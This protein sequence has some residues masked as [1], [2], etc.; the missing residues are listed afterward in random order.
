MRMSRAFLS[1]LR[2]APADTE[3][4]SHVLLARSGLLSKLGAGL[5]AYLPA[6]WRTLR[7][8]S[9][10][11]REE[12]DRAGAQE[13]MLPILQP[14]E[15]W[16]ASGR[17]RRYVAD[18]IL[19]HFRDRKEAELCLGPTHEEV[20]TRVVAEKVHTYR[21]LPLNLYQ[22]QTKMR[23]E[24][25]PRFGLM[26]AR[27]FLM[28]DAYSFDVDD[29]GLDA[30]Y[31]QMDQAY[32]RIFARCGL[33]TM[34][35][36]AD[37]GAIGGGGSQE[38]MVVA[39]TGEDA[40]LHCPCGYA[41]NAEKAT[42][43]P[44]DAPAGGAPRPLRRESTPD[45]RTVE[46]LHAFFPDVPPGRMV[47]TVLYTAVRGEAQEDVAVLM[48]G[49]LEINEVKLAGHLG[50]DALQ[51]ADDAAVRR[52]TG[53]EPG[54]A[55]PIGLAAGV[56]LVADRTV[57]GLTNFLC[58]ANV[59]DV[60]CLDVNLGRDLPAPETVD[61]RLAQAG[62]GCL[63]CGAR[64]EASRGIEVGHIFKL[65]TK[66]SEAMEATFTA[67][68]GSQQPFV[69]GCYGIGVSRIAAAA[70]EQRHDESGIV[71][72]AALAPWHVHL[73]QL[74]RKDDVQTA[75]AERLYAELTEAGVEVLFDDRAA[76]A[77]IKFKDADLLGLPFRLVAG[78]AAKEGRVELGA[79]SGGERE[80]VAVEAAT[81]EIR[82]RLGEALARRA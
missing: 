80:E 45:V 43:V 44:A 47:K 50:A 33:R 57:D 36:E 25:R 4:P 59:T 29:A 9:D 39:D 1:T 58:G 8:I 73:L 13:L 37:P 67:E 64:L 18:G 61:V 22:I 12:M 5:Y 65:G 41:A 54:F 14:R 19:F 31:A 23:D 30:A 15:L 24:I 28:K 71:W 2:A 53:A 35:V 17:W 10:I 74:N 69:M 78:R 32:R 72:P 68:D 76:S 38:F 20:I 82:K 21:Q 7:K 66:Y 49:D 63:R 62:E 34:A 79:R 46:A 56:R 26:R 11:V 51:L 48:R 70:V 27:E 55:G 3:V 42:S 77:G 16:D 52:M 40:L 6:L 60:H 81:A 75:V